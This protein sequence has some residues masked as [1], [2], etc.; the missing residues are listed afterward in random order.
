MEVKTILFPSSYFDGRKVDE[1]LINEYE[2]AVNMGLWDILF[3]DYDKWFSEGRL[4]LSGPVE[5]PVCAVHRGWMMKA[6][7]YS[8]FYQDH[9]YLFESLIRRWIYGKTCRKQDSKIHWIF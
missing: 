8:N 9:A 5:K 3:F 2:A 4:V 6:D 7:R 1:D